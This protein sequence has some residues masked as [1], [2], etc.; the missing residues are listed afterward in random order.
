MR[1]TEKQGKQIVIGVSVAIPVVVAI[2]YVLPGIET[3]TDLS[4]LPL[5]NA[6]L[7]G[8]TSLLLIVALI[9]IK[10][11]QKKMHEKLMLASLV[12]SVL[13]LISYV[14]YHLFTESTP[15]GGDAPLKYVYLFILLTH[16]LLSVAIV[17]LV[18]I[19]TVRALTE[20]Y[21]KHRK[22]ARITWPLWL[23]VTITGVVVYIM[24]SPY[25]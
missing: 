24:I 8:T 14:I 5:L 23:Y 6:V 9:A 11:K 4:F 17:P 15:Y 2:L 16:I 10:K 7:N 1:L 3:E 12:L 21:D 13:F 19:T 18:L 20:K 25:Y 22:I